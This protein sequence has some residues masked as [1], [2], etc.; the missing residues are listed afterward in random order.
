MREEARPAIEIRGLSR[1]FGSMMALSD[2]SLS[3]RRGEIRALLGPNGAGKTTLL[4]ILAGLTA[5]SQGAAY[6]LGHDIVR[7]SAAVQR[8]VGVIPSGD[9]TFYQR[10][11]G[12][13]NLVF[14]ARLYGL[15]RRE[16]ARR[17]R[18]ALGAIDL[19]GREHLMVG[20]Y[21]QGMLKR[22][23]IARA[24][25]TD[26]TVLLVDEATHNLDPEGARHVRDLVQAAADRG[27][28]VLWATQ[29]VEEIRGFADTVTL[30]HQG[31]V[32]FAGTPSQLVALAAPTRF[33]LRIR[34][35]QLFSG[36]VLAHLEAALGDRGELTPDGGGDNEHF[37]L[38]IADG[39]TLGEAIAA[40]TAADCQVLS[41]HETRS[42][43]EQAFVT[44]TKDS[45]T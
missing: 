17:V 18:E 30:I 38:T 15:S 28:A 5:P 1:R 4:R 12:Y 33:L 13:E 20:K 8:L 31:A 23:A 44:L 25:L 14:F 37:V 43:I 29:R 41:C 2:V 11:S 42:E 35:G 45:A 9:R 22:L 40:L 39:A 26:P 10:L 21:S 32:R 24:L 6:V 19:M 36:P 16:A 3:V 7:P 34:N 27:T